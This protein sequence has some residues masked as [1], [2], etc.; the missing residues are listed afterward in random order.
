MKR[1]SKIILNRRKRY[2]F[3]IIQPLSIVFALVAEMFILH[4]NKLYFH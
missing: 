4:P 2:V 3:D 1:L